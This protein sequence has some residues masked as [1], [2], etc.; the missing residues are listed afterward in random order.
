MGSQSRKRSALPPRGSVAVVAGLIAS[1]WVVGYLAASGRGNFDWIA[2]TA[3]AT[4]YGTL[5]L[6]LVTWQLVA[7]TRADASG[8]L[9]LARLAER[10]Q[11][12]RDR[13][14]RRER[15]ERV[16]DAVNQLVDAAITAEANP[17]VGNPVYRAAQARLRTAIAVSAVPIEKLGSTEMLL[18]VPLDVVQNQAASATQYEIAPLLAAIDQEPPKSLPDRLPT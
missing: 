13:S 12:A 6:A 3:A 18:R 11:E 14:L 16:L 8:T 15:I 1:F 10:E 17:N 2:A 7:L 5:A 4:G 9:E